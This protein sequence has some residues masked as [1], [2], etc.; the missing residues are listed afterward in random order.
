MILIIEDDD[1]SRE[2]TATLLRLDG[3]EV[4]TATDGVHALQILDGHRP[5]LILSDLKMPRMDGWEFRR[6]QLHSTELA[7][8]PYVIVSAV[9]NLEDEGQLLA[10]AATIA[11]PADIDDI[12]RYA[13]KYDS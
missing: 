2:L 7:E 13:K 8:I 5:S 4:V 9:M 12:L 3:H 1:T 6:R 10:A 11:K